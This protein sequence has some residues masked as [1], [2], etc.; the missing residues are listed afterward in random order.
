MVFGLE[1]RADDPHPALVEPA[2]GSRLSYAGLWRRVVDEAAGMRR[3]TGGGP[4]LLML[5][6]S[7]DIDC[8]VAYLAALRANIAVMPLPPD[9]SDTMIAILVERYRPDLIRRRRL[10]EAGE[11]RAE[12]ALWCL[13]TRAEPAIHSDLA[14]L[15]S[16]SG[17]SGSPKCVRLTL[18][19][20][21]ANASQIVTALAIGRDERAPTSLPLS[22]SYGLSVLNSH[23]AAGAAVILTSES[24]AM[25]PFWRIMAEHGGTSLAGV[26]ASYEMLR[27][28]DLDQLAPQSL[29][30]LTQAGGALAP[31]LIERFHGFVT[32]RGGRFFVMY[33]QTEATA[34]I[35]V[36]AAADLPGRIGAV[37]R[38]LPGGDLSIDAVSG[39]IR[40]RG[41]NVMMGYAECRDDLAL[42]DVLGGELDTGD[43]GRLDSDGILWITGRDKRIAKIA[44]LRIGLDEVEVLATA[45]GHAGVIDGGTWLGVAL[46]ETDL[47]QRA[48]RHDFARRLG[49][50]S[51]QLRWLAVDAMPLTATGKIDYPALAAL[52]WENGT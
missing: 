18:A 48:E 39:H 47:P 29:R 38:A 27:R 17:S 49:L 4:A 32:R 11:Y 31:S 26:P 46:A 14:L 20:V 51:S 30:T 41:P 42:G 28:L 44:G 52:G 13:R 16:T 36:L 7:S 12:G 35:S 5:D 24:L 2:S 10:G 45:F 9:L 6:F 34:R 37:G 15:L 19:A 22:Y 50:H 33:G 40:Y 8:I 1:N 25:R 3:L 43:L 23:L 21:E